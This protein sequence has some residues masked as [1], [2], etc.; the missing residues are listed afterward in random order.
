[1]IRA[2]R[3]RAGEFGKKSMFGMFQAQ[4]Q[5]RIFC[6]HGTF[7]HS[8]AWAR[9]SLLNEREDALCS[10]GRNGE[11]NCSSCRQPMPILGSNNVYRANTENCA[12]VLCSECLEENV[13]ESGDNG[14]ADQRCPLCFPIGAPLATTEVEYRYSKGE[15][16]HGDYFR[17]QGHSS[18]MTA[19]ISDVREDLWR[20][21]RQVLVK[22]L[23]NLTI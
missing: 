12:H 22:R 17:P 9:R 8:F 5:L 20:T 7:Q 23:R 16:E 11:I 4:L 13:P 15:G 3:Q 10:I 2:I 19:L 1:M 18:K 6:N 14:N 21:K